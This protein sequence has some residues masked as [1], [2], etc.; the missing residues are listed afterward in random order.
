MTN[1]YRLTPEQAI[2]QDARYI[3]RQADYDERLTFDLDP[4]RH[5]PAEFWGV[6]QPERVPY[7]APRMNCEVCGIEGDGRVCIPCVRQHI[8][9]HYRRTIWWYGLTNEQ[10]D[11]AIA[12]A[13][14]EREHARGQSQSVAL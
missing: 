10:I 8:A 1:Q 7:V 11:Y 2:E 5:T 13:R 9:R 4:D 12:M 3:D 14:K 6:R